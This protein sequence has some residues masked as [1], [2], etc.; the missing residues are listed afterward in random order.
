M[1]KEPQN[2]LKKNIATTIGELSL[3]QFNVLPKTG[4]PKETEWTVLACIVQEQN[5]NFEVVSLGTGSKCIGKTKMCP[6]GTI[7]NDSHAEVICR[8][9]FIRYLYTCMTRDSL[10]FSFN[11]HSNKFS[12]KPNI[13]FH[14]F[15][16]RVPCGDAA[17]F[18][19]ENDEDIS[20]VIMSSNVEEDIPSKKRKIDDI[21]RTGAKC[22]EHDSKQD[23]KTVGSDYH[24]FGVVRTKPGRGDRTASVSCSDKLAKW[25]HLGIQG[26]LLMVLLESPIYLSSFTILDEPEFCQEAL[27]RALYGRLDNVELLLPFSRN[28]LDVYKI[29]IDFPYSKKQDNQPCSSSIIWFKTHKE[30]FLEVAVNGRR[31]GAT[32]KHLF[33]EKGQL[34]ICKLELFKMFINKLKEF[35]IPVPSQGDLDTLTYSDAKKISIIY[36]KNWIILKK[37]FGAWSNKDSTLLNFVIN[38]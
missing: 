24:V 3:T 20:G 19:K 11:E 16:T 12:L 36:Q 17:I 23:L 21:Y 28:I 14:F 27:S 9:A 29:N 13:K 7:L 35:S 30:K 15:T 2:L 31:Q 22:L 6:K 37:K 38:N 5:S 8:R 18:P 1:Q 4:K 10:I 26:A 25:C 33:S 34:K 32:K